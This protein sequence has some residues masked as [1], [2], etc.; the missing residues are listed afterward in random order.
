MGVGNPTLLY[1]HLINFYKFSTSA[2]RSSGGSISTFRGLLQNDRELA[3]A[4]TV[5]TDTAD[6]RS[7]AGV[8]MFCSMALRSGCRSGVTKS[9]ETGRAGVRVA[10][11]RWRGGSSLIELIYKTCAKPYQRP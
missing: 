2:V 6:Y 3:R 10:W 4:I 8:G 11:P 1:G 7:S 9:D 5:I